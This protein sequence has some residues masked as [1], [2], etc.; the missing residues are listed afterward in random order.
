MLDGGVYVPPGIDQQRALPAGVGSELCGTGIT[1]RQFEVLKL[2]A[3]GYSNREI[4]GTLC[5]TEHTVKAHIGALFQTLGVG[6]RTQCVR[7]AEDRGL[8]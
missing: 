4:A 3:K 6:S 5:V 7:V 2:L 1:R 8:I